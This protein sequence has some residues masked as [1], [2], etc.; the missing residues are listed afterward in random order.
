MELVKRLI[1]RYAP[2]PIVRF[3]RRY[4]NRYYNNLSNEQVFTRIYQS[5]AWGKS[6]DVTRP[7]YSG[8]GSRR[9]DEVA[10]YI[11]SISEFLSSFDVKPDVV[12]LGCGDFSV[13]SR[14]RCFCK[15]YVA[16]DVVPSLIEHNRAHHADLAVEFRALDL[17]KD[18]LPPGD[19]ALDAAGT[20]A[21]VQ[22]ADW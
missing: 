7:F 22:R 1:K 9:D 10:T 12:D 14:V 4:N 16:C 5:G 13:G 17:A 2:E 8:S 11:R 15:R 3:V 18:E 19:V 6:S 20:S 21:F